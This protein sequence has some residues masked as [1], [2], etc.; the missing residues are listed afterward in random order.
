[1]NTTYFLNQIMG[2]VFKSKTDPALPQKYYLGV[3]TT[4]PNVNGTGVTEPTDSGSGY[5]RIEI[6][7]LSEP[8]N[9]AI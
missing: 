1:M 9:G 8:T 5:K 4:E 6:T 2:N 3:S 7:G